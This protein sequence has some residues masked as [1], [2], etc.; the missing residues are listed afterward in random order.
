MHPNFRPGIKQPSS[1]STLENGIPKSVPGSMSRNPGEG[2]RWSSGPATSRPRNPGAMRSGELDLQVRRPIND[3]ARDRV[4]GGRSRERSAKGSASNATGTL[5]PSATNGLQRHRLQRTKR[6][7]GNS[8]ILP[9]APGIRFEEV[10][11]DPTPEHSP[12]N[13]PPPPASEDPTEAVPIHPPRPAEPAVSLNFT[14]PASV[15]RVRSTTRSAC[16]PASDQIRTDPPRNP[17][18]S[19]SAGWGHP[20]TTIFPKTRGG[21]KRI[22]H[23]G[24]P[25]RSEATDSSP[26]SY[27]MESR[28]IGGDSGIDFR[29]QRGRC[30]GSKVSETTNAQATETH[31][32]NTPD[33]QVGTRPEARLQDQPAPQ[34]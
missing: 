20:S 21:S 33:P 17:S 16:S 22:R 23:S 5:A 9:F 6:I 30:T 19:R 11:R 13:A 27:E 12:R 1:L 10:S 15:A 28:G 2:V 4:A 29:Q 24:K 7:A 34:P 14:I 26:S 25:P 32:G 3:P 8:R 18:S 31:Q